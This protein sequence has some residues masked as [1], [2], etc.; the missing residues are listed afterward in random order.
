MEELHALT[1]LAPHHILSQFRSRSLPFFILFAAPVDQQTLDRKPWTLR[2]ARRCRP[3]PPSPPPQ[4]ENP[5]LRRPWAAPSRWTWIF[6]KPIL[7]VSVV[8]YTLPTVDSS[9]E[10]EEG[11]KTD[12]ETEAP[13]RKPNPRQRLGTNPGAIIKIRR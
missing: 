11:K 12:A 10:G 4:Q 6:S 8:R 5:E 1:I 2:K 13:E 9:K 3:R 7:F